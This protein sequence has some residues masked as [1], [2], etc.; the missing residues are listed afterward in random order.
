MKFFLFNSNAT[1]IFSLSC[2]TFSTQEQSLAF[3]IGQRVSTWKKEK[4][5]G[6]VQVVYQRASSCNCFLI[7]GISQCENVRNFPSMSFRLNSAP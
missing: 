7:G 3:I 5:F 6:K 1:A 2:T 4:K